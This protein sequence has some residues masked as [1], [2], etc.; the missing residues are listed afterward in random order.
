MVLEIKLLLTISFFS[1]IRSKKKSQL[2]DTGTH[3][4]P[5]IREAE[6][7][8]SLNLRLASSTKLFLR[9]PRLHRETLSRKHTHTTESLK[10][11]DISTSAKGS[12]A[13]L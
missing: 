2:V 5:N 9:Q 1:V 8:R 4:E 13:Q 10:N 7:V 11:P 6:A 3:L 12:G